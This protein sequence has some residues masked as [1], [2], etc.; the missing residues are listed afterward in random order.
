VR[1]LGIDPGTA[2]TGYGLVD[3][4]EELRLVE[5]GAI[6]TPVGMTLPQR[7]LIIHRRPE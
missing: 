7:L 4:A 5:C 3:F 2:I 1:V 6:V